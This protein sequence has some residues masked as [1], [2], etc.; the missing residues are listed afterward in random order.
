[1]FDYKF[2]TKTG[3]YRL[4]YEPDYGFLKSFKP[5]YVKP[6]LDGIVKDET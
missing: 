4:G 2:I 1:V 6:I 5:L 3:I